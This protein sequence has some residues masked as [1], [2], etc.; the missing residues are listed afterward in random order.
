MAKKE[1]RIFNSQVLSRKVQDTISEISEILGIDVTH[2][3]AVERPD[4]VNKCEYGGDNEI[5]VGEYHPIYARRKLADFVISAAEF[6]ADAIEN[7]NGDFARETG[8]YDLDWVEGYYVCFKDTDEPLKLRLTDSND[9]QYELISSEDHLPIWV[10]EDRYNADVVR[11][12]RDGTMFGTMG[13][14]RHGFAQDNLEV[15][16]TQIRIERST[17]Q[18]M[19]K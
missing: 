14:P 13:R 1:K 5:R 9:G 4:Y 15:K 12:Q 16:P 7:N 3:D 2:L 11:E 6:A 8:D 18:E 10:A 17:K 19:K